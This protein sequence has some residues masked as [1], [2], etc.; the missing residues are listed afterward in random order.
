MSDEAPIFV[1]RKKGRLSARQLR[2]A[3]RL[4]QE[5]AGFERYFSFHSLR[6]SACT[7]LYRATRDIRLTQRFARHK[8]ILSTA[9]YTHPTDEDLSASVADLPC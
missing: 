6:H 4:W 9:I 3:F 1:S 2:H 8:S 7:N 5:R